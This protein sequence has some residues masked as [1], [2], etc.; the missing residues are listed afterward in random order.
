MVHANKL[1]RCQEKE[2]C[3]YIVEK[4]LNQGNL[5][6][7]V[8]ITTQSDLEQLAKAKRIEAQLAHKKEVEK[9]EKELKKSETF[10]L[11]DAVKNENSAMTKVSSDDGRPYSPRVAS[12]YSTL[13]P[14]SGNSSRIKTAR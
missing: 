10:K 4:V 14:F 6:K 12:A 7:I 5:T 13:G 2:V 3:K 1:E 9:Q 8:G 11:D